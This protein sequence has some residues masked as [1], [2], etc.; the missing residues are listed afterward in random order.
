M[1]VYDVDRVEVDLPNGRMELEFDP[2]TLRYRNRD[3]WALDIFAM[4]P[5]TRTELERLARKRTAATFHVIARGDKQFTLDGTVE[6][7]E[8]RATVYPAGRNAAMTP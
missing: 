8:K 4:S 2:A 7:D 5:S 1:A 3:A 6:I